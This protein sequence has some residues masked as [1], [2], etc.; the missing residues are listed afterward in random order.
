M[1]H[2]IKSCPVKISEGV[3]LV[4]TPVFSQYL[5]KSSNGYIL[6][7]GGVSGQY[8]ELRKQIGDLGVD[9]RDIKTLVI[10]HAHFDH[11]M[12]F[13]LLKKDFPWVKI[14]APDR[15]KYVFND[16]KILSK[17]ISTD[18][19]VS[20]R[21]LELGIAG[22]LYTI[23]P[24]DF[25]VDHFFSEGDGL[26]D[27][28]FIYVPGHSPDSMAAFLKSDRILFVSDA[29]GG[30]LKDNLYKPNYFYSVK[31]FLESLHKVKKIGAE[32]LCL[33]HNGFL[34]GRV[35]VADF[36][37]MAIHE[38]ENF[39]K[40]IKDQIKKGRSID[41][42]IEDLTDNFSKGFL[43]LFSREDNLKM[44]RIIVERSREFSP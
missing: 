36:F 3:F 10:L 22:E 12:T 15:S 28:E 16:Q 38:T 33:G 34:R 9:P 6:F 43:E 5:V 4:G 31:D 8:V 32:V 23:N 2:F 29:A 44:W 19:E 30:L 35:K 13:P 42:L 39:V 25:C 21:L 41:D 7:E 37:D 24:E 14:W 11:I 18:R 1:E 40:Y 17:I 26:D 27:I 20:R